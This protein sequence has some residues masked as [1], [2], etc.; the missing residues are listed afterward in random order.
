[1]KRL[2]LLT[3]FAAALCSPVTAQVTHTFDIQTAKPGAVIQPTM[4]GIFFEDINFGADG[5]LYAEMVKNRSFEFE[6]P[7]MGWN[8][9]GN[10]E[11]RDDGPFDR[12]PHYARLNFSGHRVKHTAIENEGFFGISV[13]KGETYKFSVYARVPE[14]AG[15]KAYFE[16]QICDKALDLNQH[17]LASAKITVEGNEWEKYEVDL[18]PFATCEDGVLRIF[19]RNSKFRKPQNAVDGPS[20]DLEHVS[21][22]P[23]KTWKDRPGGM[24]QDLAQALYDLHPGIFRFPGGCIVEGT[25]LAD[26][27]QWKHTVGPVENRPLNLNRWQYEFDYRFYPDYYQSYGLG[28]FEYFQLSEDFGAEPLPVLNCGMTCQYENPIEGEAT[29]HVAVEDL[30]PYI[31]DAVDLVEFANGDVSTTWGKLR[32]EMGHPEPFNLKFLAIGNEQWDYKDNPAY[33]KRLARFIE[34]LRKKCPGIKIIG[35]TGPNSEGWDFD[36][37]QPRMKQLGVDLY[38]EHFYRN[39]EWFLSHGCATIVTTVRDQRSSRANMPAM[40]RANIP[41][42]RKRSVTIL[43][44]RS[45]KPPSSQ[46]LNAMPTSSIWP[47][48]LHSLPTSRA[49]N[50]VPTLSGSTTSVP[51]VPSVTTFSS[52]TVITRVQ[53]YCRSRW[54]ANLWPDKRDK[55]DSSQA[56]WSM[57]LLVL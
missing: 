43:R 57:R 50:G 40:E 35:T 45:T 36:L 4:Y 19:L 39:E 3:L 13:K 17:K 30:D 44:L 56:L 54:Q 38:D 20:L 31:Q 52:S 22:F 25:D 6:N 33:T 15:N 2:S 53:T 37:L 7:W 55:T 8:T 41:M 9:T 34:V 51:S 5:G 48:T 26:R 10:V 42:A 49:G 32:A 23:A 21:L 16:V 29:Y 46:V 18:T 28:F 47:P 14:E 12:N 1:M 11:I 27:Y 24:R